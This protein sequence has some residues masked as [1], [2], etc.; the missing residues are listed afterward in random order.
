MAIATGRTFRWSLN[1][2]NGCKK[3]GESK[4]NQHQVKLKL[5]AVE[6][7]CLVFVRLN[8]GVSTSSAPVCTIV[9]KVRV[10][11]ALFWHTQS[12]GPATCITEGAAGSRFSRGQGFKG[13]QDLP[14]QAPGSCR[15]WLDRRLGL[16][17]LLFSRVPPRHH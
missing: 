7:R 8:F 5:D 10:V 14:S 1:N 15:G 12:A 11:N 9:S 2:N 17:R 13:L 3:R 16:P 6:S 4:P